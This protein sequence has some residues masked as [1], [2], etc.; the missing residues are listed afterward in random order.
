MQKKI[1]S[2]QFESRRCMDG[3]YFEGSTWSA[4]P[5]LF[6]YFLAIRQRRNAS[7]GQLFSIH[8]LARAA[9]H[10]KQAIK[11]LCFWIRC[12]SHIRTRNLHICTL[13][14]DV[15][16]QKVADALKMNASNVRRTDKIEM[17][18]Y[19]LQIHAQQ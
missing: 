19:R 8:Y 12:N 9:K 7:D 15:D 4:L 3:T 2:L 18:L 10:D 14:A 6:S 11:N 1:V 16:I 13:I 5:N 17:F